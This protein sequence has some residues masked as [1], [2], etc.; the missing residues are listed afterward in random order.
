MSDIIKILRN[1]SGA[2]RNVLNRQL[3]DAESYTIPYSQWT[4]LADHT[5]TLDDITA[6]YVVVNN[7]TV[8]LSVTDAFKLIKRFDIQDATD[9]PF[10]NSSN[11]FIATTTQGAVEEALTSAT[12]ISRWATCCG[13][14]G[15]AS[16]GRYLEYSANVD[17]DKAGLVITRNCLLK[18]LGL[19]CNTVSTTTI[20]ILKWDGVSETLLTSISLSS[21]QKAILTGL[22]VSLVALDE[23]RVKTSSGSSSRPILWQYFQNT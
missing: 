15:S 14:D 8:D 13:F 9:T 3:A 5:I 18:E 11:G 17:S 23:I 2:T 10:D 12:S 20:Q 7:G 4:K 16:V 21:Q 1:V 6:G 22:N 19:T